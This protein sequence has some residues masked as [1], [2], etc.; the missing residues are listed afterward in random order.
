MNM[1]IVGDPVSLWL[2]GG[3][4]LGSAMRAFLTPAQKTLSRKSIA[5]VVIGGAVGLLYPL[6][7]VVPLPGGASP[8]QLAVVMFVLAYFS[9][10]FLVNVV[11]KL[12]ALKKTEE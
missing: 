11:T 4:L 2:A 8:L 6:Y 10:D 12:G 9:S 5:D 1:S 7:P 3:A